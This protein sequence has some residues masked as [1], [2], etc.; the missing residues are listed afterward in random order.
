MAG[1]PTRLE[2][3][4][5][6][7]QPVEIR[8]ENFLDRV[9]EFRRSVQLRLQTERYDAAIFR[10]PWEGLPIVEALPLSVYEVHGFPSTELAS[11]FP[12]IRNRPEIVDRLIGEENSCLARARLFLTPS[13]T[14]RQYLMR[15][16]VHPD[17]IRVIPNSFDA[18]EVGDLGPIPPLEGPVRV[19][20]M[21][22]LAPWQGLENLLEALALSRRE[23]REY[24]LVVAGTRKGRW[25]RRLRELA[26][27]LR[28]KDTLELH[29]PLPKDQLFQLLGS[30]HVL[31][32]PLPDDPRNGMQGCCPIKIL[33]YMACRR[34][35]LSTRIPPVEE[36]LKDNESACL[37]P[38]NS[39]SW[40]AR[41]LS[42][43]LS[44]PERAAGLADTAYRRLTSDFPRERFGRQLQAVVEELNCCALTRLRN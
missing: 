35:I 32:A 26:S 31:A 16:G 40:L 42:R 23:G 21:G 7:H 19:G 14:S 36:I 18:A 44:D 27:H 39:A 22:T 25:S 37:V 2:G 15:R 41:G 17:K 10:S 12:E 43:L 3:D 5:I 11:H 20:Y 13:L 9:L 28:L 34:P 38:P 6:D 8:H 29:G 1:F 24:R 33:E 30:C 4:N